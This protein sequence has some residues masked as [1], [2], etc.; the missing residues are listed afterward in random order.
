MNMRI[1]PL[2]CLLL[3]WAADACTMQQQVQN[4]QVAAVAAKKKQKKQKVNAE[5]KESESATATN[6]VTE[7]SNVA[8]TPVAE[9]KTKEHKKRVLL[10]SL[11]GDP[12]CPWSQEVE[13]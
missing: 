1:Q 2:I 9:E 12:K 8:N 6:V 7:E 10:C 4:Q 11:C 13:D 3:L 5:T